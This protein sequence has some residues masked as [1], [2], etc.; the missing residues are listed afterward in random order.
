MESA[1]PLARGLQNAYNIN[2]RYDMTLELT[3]LIKDYH[4]Y[5]FLFYNALCCETELLYNC[6]HDDHDDN[7]ILSK[8]QYLEWKKLEL[9]VTTSRSAL[10]TRFFSLKFNFYVEIIIS[11]SHDQ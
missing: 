10:A 6:N 3:L 4:V 5:I 2:C 8:D 7:E 1:M 9:L 11:T